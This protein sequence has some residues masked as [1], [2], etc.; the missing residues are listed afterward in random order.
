MFCFCFKLPNIPLSQSFYFKAK[1]K[2]TLARFT[3]GSFDF[4]QTRPDRL[5]D[6]DRKETSQKY[7]GDSIF[8][9][10]I[11]PSPQRNRF[12]RSSLLERS[13]TE[14]FMNLEDQR[15]SFSRQSLDRH[16]SSSPLV[17]SMDTLGSTGFRGLLQAELKLGRR[18]IAIGI[19][20]LFIHS[21]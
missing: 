12:D 7:R 5:A 6:R 3:L 14:P 18:I 1:E 21:Y 9:G 20:P 11:P 16:R 2:D 8:N 10:S 13:T 15:L 4:D 19:N 17:K